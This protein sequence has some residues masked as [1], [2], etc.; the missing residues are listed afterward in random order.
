[1][2]LLYFCMDWGK[3]LDKNLLK[4]ESGLLNEIQLWNY[5]EGTSIKSYGYD[6]YPS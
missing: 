3:K 5:I 4:P 6:K 2:S 1:M